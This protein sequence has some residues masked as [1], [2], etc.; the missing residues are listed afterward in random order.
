[1]KCPKCGSVHIRRS[2]PRPWEYVVKRFTRKRPHRCENCRWRGWLVHQRRRGGGHLAVETKN[3]VAP[4]P[5][6]PD[7][8][9][10]DD[11]LRRK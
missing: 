8:N 2:R 1:M 5:R 3:A 10:I 9:A 4:A 7:L 11:G 6:E